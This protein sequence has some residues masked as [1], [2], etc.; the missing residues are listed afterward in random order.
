[1]GFIFDEH[2]IQVN[3]AI[4]RSR[5]LVIGLT[6]DYI[7]SITGLRELSK[8]SG[9]EIRGRLQKSHPSVLPRSTYFGK[10]ITRF[11]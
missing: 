3:D 7:K 10:R 8:K 11:C 1:M 4:K 6:E 2:Y 9:I 5:C